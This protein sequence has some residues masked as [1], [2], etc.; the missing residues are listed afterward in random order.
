MQDHRQVLVPRAAAHVV[1]PRDDD[2][3]NPGLDENPLAHQPGGPPEAEV[4]GR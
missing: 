2:H 1:Q 4:H 3:P